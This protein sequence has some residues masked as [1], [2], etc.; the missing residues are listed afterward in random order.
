MV[1]ALV[2]LHSDYHSLYK[3]DIHAGLSELKN[4]AAVD[5]I[6]THQKMLRESPVP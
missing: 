5:L 2:A 6:E 3:A 4:T 1:P